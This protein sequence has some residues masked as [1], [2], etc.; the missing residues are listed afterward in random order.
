M[1]KEITRNW[2]VVHLNRHARRKIQRPPYGPNLA[3]FKV[4]VPDVIHRA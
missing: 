3:G 1:S 4:T 2:A